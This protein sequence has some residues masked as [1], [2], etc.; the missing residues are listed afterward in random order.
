MKKIVLAKVKE[1]PDLVRDLGTQ[2]ILNTNKDA[3]L[4]Y[5]KQK[6]KQQEIDKSIDDINMMKQEMQEIKTLMQRILD[7][8]G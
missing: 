7:K 4:A 3:L 2:A 1:N 6:A 5:K 8:I